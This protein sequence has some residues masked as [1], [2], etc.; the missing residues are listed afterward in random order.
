MTPPLAA[1][2]V[3]GPLAG[4]AQIIPSHL[5]TVVASNTEDMARYAD[6]P[7]PPGVTEYDLVNLYPSLE[8]RDDHR[9]VL[10]AVAHPFDLRT[11]PVGILNTLITVAREKVCTTPSIHAR[12][13]VAGGTAYERASLERA[14]A[15]LEREREAA[16]KR[17]ADS[18]I[19]DAYENGYAA[20]AR[21]ALARDPGTAP[22][23]AQ[24]DHT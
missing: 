2:F 13:L 10:L 3:G 16:E 14:K 18:A 1:L 12:D 15:Y 7:R 23:D 20:G 5:Y 19:R 6:P 4:Q 17:Q 24:P 8:A 9:P 21:A 11:L 22:T